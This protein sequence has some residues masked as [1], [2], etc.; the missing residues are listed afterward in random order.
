MVTGFRPQLLAK[1]PKYSNDSWQT[2]EKT[3]VG[4]HKPEAKRKQKSKNEER[5]KLG[6]REKTE[7][8]NIKEEGRDSLET[9][10]IENYHFTEGKVKQNHRIVN[11]P[12]T[13]L[14]KQTAEKH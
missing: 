5:R 12:V 11:I 7:E 3:E 13:R 14:A 6:S 2:A 4:R 8:K 1:R 9:E 10:Q